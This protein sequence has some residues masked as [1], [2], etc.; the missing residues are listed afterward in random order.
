[1]SR[2]RPSPQQLDAEIEAYLRADRSTEDAR[3]RSLRH[4][5]DAVQSD[6]LRVRPGPGGLSLHEKAQRRRDLVEDRDEIL[7]Q[8]RGQ[9]VSLPTYDAKRGWHGGDRR[10]LYLFTFPDYGAGETSRV[11]PGDTLPSKLISPQATVRVATRDEATRGWQDPLHG[12]WHV[13]D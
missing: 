7:R 1:M 2:A 12:G 10:T 11:I 9:P 6:L 13:T 5:L 3:R 8:L 4:R